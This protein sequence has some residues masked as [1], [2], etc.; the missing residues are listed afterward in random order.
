[1]TQV[2]R[3]L[4]RRGKRDMIRQARGRGAGSWRIGKD[5]QIRERQ[6]FD[7]GH[8]RRKVVVAFPWEPHDDVGAESEDREPRRESLDRAAVRL[9]CV[10]VT[11]HAAQQPIRSR[12]QWRMEMRSDAQRVGRQQLEQLVVH[13]GRL[14]RRQT[15]ANARH[16]PDELAYQ[17]P[18]RCT[19]VRAVRS[20]VRSGDHDL[21]MMLGERA[22]FAH[23]IVDCTTA[24]CSA[25]E[26]RR[27]KGAVLVAAILDA[28]HCAH[29][30]LMVR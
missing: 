8:G 15:K 18:E 11:S 29:R 22:C 5:V 9:R 25:R 10:P 16:A 7:E 20:D 24:I 1:M 14:E 13:L 17:R 30:R 21:R 27:A 6:P 28:Q 2:R 23:E 19:D 3:T 12:L 4:L 26:G